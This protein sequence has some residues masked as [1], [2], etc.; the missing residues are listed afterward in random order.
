MDEKVSV[1][2]A[3]KPLSNVRELQRSIGMVQY[4]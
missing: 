2:F 4:Y 1:I 3:L